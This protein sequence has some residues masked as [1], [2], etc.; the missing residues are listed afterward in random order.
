M[1]K[2]ICKLFSPNIYSKL[3]N[4][5]NLQRIEQQISHFVFVGLFLLVCF[6]FVLCRVL[7]CYPKNRFA[8][9]HLAIVLFSCVRI[10]VKQVQIN[11]KE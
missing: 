9:S 2:Q 1:G 10:Y 4:T 3:L 6:L 5:C 8:R 11:P 7:F